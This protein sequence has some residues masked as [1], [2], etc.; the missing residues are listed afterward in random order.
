[1]A[2]SDFVTFTIAITNAGLS[3][4]SF[5]TPL[6]PSYSAPFLGTREY[7]QTSDVA[8]DF[9]VGTVEHTAAAAIF[10]QPVHPDKVKIAAATLPPTLQYTLG[11]ATAVNAT[12]YQVQVDGPGITSTL[13]SVTSDSSATIP[14]INSALLTA[15][16]AVVGANYTAAFQLL[17]F[18]DFAVTADSATDE[19]NHTAHGLNTGDGP[20]QITNSGGALPAGLT[21]S[22]N[23]W[24][25]KVDANNFKL[26]AS[27]ALALAGTPID[28]TTNGTGTQTIN[29]QT[30]T[31]SPSLA[32]L[33]TGNAAGNWFSLEVKDFALLSNKMT[34]ADPGIATTLAAIKAV[35]D[36]WYWLVMPWASRTMLLATA[37][38]VETNGKVYLPFSIETDSINQAAGFGD[39]LDTLKGFG[40]TRTA[41]KWHPSPVQMFDAAS[42]GA[43]APKAPG[44]YTEA[45]KT[46]TGVQ[47]VKLSPTQRQNLKDRRAGSYTTERGRNVTWDGKVGSTVYG[48]L[49]IRVVV[50]WFS[51]QVIGAVLGVL[52][53]LD[54]VAFTDEDISAVAGAIRGV[55]ANAV[56][57]AHK[58]LDPGDPT[59]TDN[60]PPAVTF[61][62]VVDI[63]PATRAL[64]QLP[65]GLITGR[66]QGAVQSVQFQAVLTF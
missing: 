63:S 48:Y 12:K 35:D 32:L 27:L 10:A 15:L 36:D 2:D 62:K 11:A 38:W 37:A 26:A 14:K 45:F 56:S 25:I 6:I 22:T 55:I 54:K 20:V 66:F 46:L 7:G 52:F 23:Y 8:A 13:V 65:N 59:S 60:P 61:P 21:G 40:Y 58:A 49:D 29:H 24:V 53:S 51:S 57:D 28:L 42:I 44:T 31:A 4:P 47:P 16:N 9:A 50:D 43:I 34:H 17:A 41:A 19:L 18:T 39:A 5:A 64:R 1:M 3:Q 33:V 30:A